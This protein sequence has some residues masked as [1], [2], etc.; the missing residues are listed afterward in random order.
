MVKPA[1][2]ELEDGVP[3]C[4]VSRRGI[5]SHLGTDQQG[6]NRRAKDFTAGPKTKNPGRSAS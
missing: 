5:Q 2:V 1:E 3:K 6:H 4:S